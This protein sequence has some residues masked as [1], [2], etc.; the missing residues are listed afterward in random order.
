[1]ADE[2]PQ[3]TRKSRRSGVFVTPQKST[4]DA[5]FDTYSE[6]SEEQQEFAIR[7]LAQI[8]RMRTRYLNTPDK[9]QQLP[10]PE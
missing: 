3:G 5:W 10:Q 9:Q 4:E 6:W 2:K 1:M 8:Q 7:V